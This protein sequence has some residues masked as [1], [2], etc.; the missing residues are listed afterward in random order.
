MAKYSVLSSLLMLALLLIISKE[1]ISKE[2]RGNLPARFYL[3]CKTKH[4]PR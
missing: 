3:R 1:E 4:S 2:E